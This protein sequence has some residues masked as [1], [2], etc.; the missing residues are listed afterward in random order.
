VGQGGGIPDVGGGRSWWWQLGPRGIIHRRGD[1]AVVAAAVRALAAIVL[2]TKTEGGRARVW[3]GRQFRGAG[4]SVATIP[5][6][7]DSPIGGQEWPAG[8]T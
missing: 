3:S 6:P 7:L 8:F 5:S 1:W 4:C 2:N